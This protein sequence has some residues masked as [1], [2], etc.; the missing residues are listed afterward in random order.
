MQQT[1]TSTSS[2]A[3]NGNTVPETT[4]AEE[5]PDDNLLDKEL[6]DDRVRGRQLAKFVVGFIVFLL[7]FSSMLFSKL[8]FVSLAHDI[9]VQ[10]NDTFSTIRYNDSSQSCNETSKYWKAQAYWRMYWVI[11]IPYAFC[12]LRC[13]W[14]SLGKPRFRFPWPSRGLFAKVR[15][16]AM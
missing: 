16:D 10:H 4:A 9:G 13:A 11:F 2:E 5:D 12:L 14:Q 7:T 15:D 8:S 6:H 3:A 1:D